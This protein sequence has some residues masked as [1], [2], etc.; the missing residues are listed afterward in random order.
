MRN[1]LLNRTLKKNNADATYKGF[2][3]LKTVLL[4]YDEPELAHRKDVQALAEALTA[5]GKK[6]TT[7]CLKQ[8]KKPKENAAAS[9]Y[10]KADVSLIKKPMKHILSNLP[11]SVDLLIDWTK[12]AGSPNDF[13]AASVHAPLKLGINKNLS[14][15]ALNIADKGHPE[16]T[17][18]NEIMKYL[19]LINHE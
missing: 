12:E 16:A 14:C 7:I 1:Y 11:A 18:I 5:S 9:M 2:A 15:F 10:F 4:V 6:V 3:R 8:G 19:K 13:I 17:V